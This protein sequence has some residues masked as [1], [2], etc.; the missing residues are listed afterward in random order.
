MIRFS[1]HTV[2]CCVSSLRV[3]RT[4][5]TRGANLAASAPPSRICYDMLPAML[6]DAARDFNHEEER[7]NSEPGHGCCDSPKRIVVAYGHSLWTSTIRGLA[8]NFY[9]AVPIL[10]AFRRQHFPSRFKAFRSSCTTPAK[11]LSAKHAYGRRYLDRVLIV[12]CL[13]VAQG[14]PNC[15][16]VHLRVKCRL[17]SC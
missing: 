6:H 2:G 3:L 11:N 9:G 7:M 13:T 10:T 1:S 8:T 12:V 17:G 5:P 14:L 4:T 15:S 16:E